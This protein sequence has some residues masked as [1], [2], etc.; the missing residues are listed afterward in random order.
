MAYK[1]EAKDVKRVRKAARDL[2]SKA[3]RQ[4][5]SGVYKA[6][7]E[8]AVPKAKQETP[9]LKGHLAKSIK[10]RGYTTKAQLT[11]G[12]GKSREYAGPIHFG[13]PAHNIEPHPFLHDAIQSEWDRIFQHWEEGVTRILTEPFEKI[14][15]RQYGGGI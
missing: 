4:E 8:I 12:A 5:L 14:L 15:E 2:E 10:V 1:V 7:A 6:S 13:W 11:A 9:V 3:I